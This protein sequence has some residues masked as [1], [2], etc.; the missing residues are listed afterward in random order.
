MIRRPRRT[1]PATITGV[2]VLAA[3]ALAAISCIQLIAGTPPLIPFTTVGRFAAT[4]TLNDPAVLAGGAV[5][6]L[7]GVVLLACA[8][9]PG[10][11][12]VLALASTNDHTD[13]GVARLSLARD[14]TA[15]AAAAD[16]ITDA[17]VTV[18]ARAV[19]VN[20]HTA[21]RDRAGLAEQVRE[22]VAPRLDDVNLARPARVRVTI[23]PER[24]AR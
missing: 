6:A 2:V 23:T 13:A 12:Q 7:L 17:H 14:L 9:L 4:T 18:G 22:R 3:A 16:G 5:L 1:I 8:L 10:T 15:H 11:P 24:S 21:L 20:A 19:T